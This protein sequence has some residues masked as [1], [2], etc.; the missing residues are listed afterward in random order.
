MAEIIIYIQK[1]HKL[2]AV[3]TKW[4]FISVQELISESA[5]LLIYLSNILENHYVE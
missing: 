4:L 1:N 2:V 3:Y 5:K